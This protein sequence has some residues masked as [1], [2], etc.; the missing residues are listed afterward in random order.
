MLTRCNGVLPYGV[1][2]VL[3]HM[4]IPFKSSINGDS[5]R[6]FVGLKVRYAVIEYNM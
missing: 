4:C 5:D 2:F 3:L 6:S 1:S